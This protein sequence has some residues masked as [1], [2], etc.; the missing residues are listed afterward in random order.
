M[1]SLMLT[2]QVRV[3]HLLENGG[4]NKTGNDYGYSSGWNPNILMGQQYRLNAD[5]TKALIEGLKAEFGNNDQDLRA[6]LQFLHE[7]S[8]TTN[9]KGGVAL[10]SVAAANTLNQF[11][12]GVGFDKRFG[13]NT[14]APIHPVG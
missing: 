1:T 9:G 8:T 6:G 12:S 7:L 4:V 5:E 10:M 2:P 14:T 11:A 13:A 3:G